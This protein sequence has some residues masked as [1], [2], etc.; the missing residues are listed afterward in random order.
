MHAAITKAGISKKTAVAVSSTILI[1]LCL[2]TTLLCSRL[3][4]VS[5][6]L[7]LDFDIKSPKALT[8]KCQYT[9]EASGGF[10]GERS[11]EAGV[12]G[13]GDFESV[14]MA[15]PCDTIQQIRIYPGETPGEISIRNI[16]ITTQ[17]REIPLGQDF[18]FHDTDSHSQQGDII[19]LSSEQKA[20]YISYAGSFC[21]TNPA[22]HID[23]FYLLIVVSLS[24]LLWVV[25]L[26]YALP[27]YFGNRSS[28]DEYR[29]SPVFVVI[30]CI[31]LVLPWVDV[32]RETISVAENR[33][34][35]PLP[36]PVK[37]NGGINANFG[38]GFDSW[39]QDHAAFRNALTSAYFDFKARMSA[40]RATAR[41]TMYKDNWM[42]MKQYYEAATTPYTDEE[43]AKMTDN[44]RRLQAWCKERNIKLYLLSCPT[45]ETLYADFNTSFVNAE[46]KAV[47]QLQAHLQTHLP[48][49]PFIYPLAAM[50]QA[51]SDKPEELLHYKSDSHQTEDGAY[52]IYREAMQ[53]IRRDFPDIPITSKE[54]NHL[55]L[56]RN[57]MVLRRDEPL[58][59]RYYEGG[60]YHNLD[61]DDENVLDTE[62]N[63]YECISPGATCKAGTEPMEFHFTFDEGKYTAML[64][65][66]SYS[67]Y[68][69]LWFRYSF[70]NMWRVRAN[71]G[72]N[73]GT[74]NMKRWES[75]LEQSP[76]DVL[77]LC[78][79]SGRLVTH[80]SALYD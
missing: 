22:S 30:F 38:K 71:N 16:R 28:S 70:K 80:L 35:A 65:G 2:I 54:G 12:S 34:L 55:K 49:L 36:P 14:R 8:L 52:I 5:D 11:V 77:I 21:A 40:V 31:L 33:A 4:M 50:Q 74:M 72:A 56:V 53:A 17:N 64:L 61:L 73:G 20:P 60:L 7:F 3:Y 69:Q 29:G 57:N 62:Y 59:N 44:L 66:D 58:E 51:R 19:T 37:E 6:P 32:S 1:L 13:S 39:L 9:P 23:W 10:T 79:C 41:V 78:I 26:R 15:I 67:S 27:L 24:A 48:E 75:A 47:P 63:H 43:L 18:T 45:K 76:P 46:M 42:F 25:V 68:Q